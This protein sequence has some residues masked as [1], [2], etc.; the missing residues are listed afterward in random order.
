MTAQQ[1]L[2]QRIKSNLE[3]KIPSWEELEK[4]LEW[5]DSLLEDSTTSCFEPTEELVE[6]L[7]WDEIGDLESTIPTN[8][9][10][11]PLCKV[12]ETIDL[13]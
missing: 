1:T 4:E 5:W 3:E 10:T 7:T 12:E 6:Q 13:D 8:D 11:L 9:S 2:I